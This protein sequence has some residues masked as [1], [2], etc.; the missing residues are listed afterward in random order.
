M[1]LG[2]DDAQKAFYTVKRRKTGQLELSNTYLFGDLLHKQLLSSFIPHFA[3]KELVN[4][5]EKRRQLYESIWLE[6]K[7]RMEDILS[8]SYDGLLSNLE[9]YMTESLNF[10]GKLPVAFTLL[11]TNSANNLRIL[12]ELSLRLASA[13]AIHLRVIA[14]NS[15]NSGNIK[16]T[17]REINRQLLA[18]KT[19]KDTEEDD[20]D[21][22]D[23]EG[24]MAHDFEIAQDWCLDYMKHEG[25]TNISTTKL[26]LVIIIQDAD[27]LHTQVLNQIINVLHIYARSIPVKLVLGLSSNEVRDWIN[28]N[29]STQLR[30]AI[31]GT[32]FKTQDNKQLAY[33]ILETLFMVPQNSNLL[34]L[35]SRLA[36]VILN[37]FERAN[38]SL[39]SLM[40]EIKLCYMTYFYHLPLSILADPSF[41]PE[42]NHITLLRELPSFKLHIERLVEE[43]NDCDDHEKHQSLRNSIDGL[44]ST[45]KEILLLV[46][47]SK[48]DL[49]NYHRH[50]V[51]NVHLIQS[52]Y[53]RSK[54]FLNLEWYKAILSG[55]LA[56]SIPFTDLKDHLLSLSSTEVSDICGQLNL[57]NTMKLDVHA[58]NTAQDL[59]DMIENHIKELDT[60]LLTSKL[61]NEVWI[62]AGGFS[63]YDSVASPYIEES[64]ENVVL[65]LLRPPLRRSLEDALEGLSDY[66]DCTSNEVTPI[67]SHLFNVYRDAPV[68]INVYDF[69]CAFKQSLPK[70]TL[71]RTMRA[72]LNESPLKNHDQ[73]LSA[74]GDV[75]NN[76]AAWDKMVF[77][78]FL[79]ASHEFVLLGL[80]K[81]RSKVDF[82]EK[83]IW[84]GL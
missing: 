5:V 18:H 75:E 11:G 16:S 58:I 31:K 29:I 24:R 22:G 17:L 8:N 65:R 44:L 56:T 1:S 51:D 38:N 27:S 43:Y 2:D 60:E 33:K 39:D 48:K 59:H 30:L 70:E 76:D 68:S 83:G 78:W 6:Q 14:L 71:L 62:L 25:S 36:A 61:F 41:V 15:K 82:F 45:N 47:T 21:F 77:S 52:C 34:I 35:D 10:D 53:G 28:G 46:Q 4:H 12:G 23:K 63:E 69:F 54:K 13:T 32:K 50:T 84:I 72:Q 7:Q 55:G 42:A 9:S 67:A 37:R 40:A 49:S 20:D 26:R 73:S 80:L 19:T 79:H 74:I 66:L 64:Y 57:N 3:G 81:E